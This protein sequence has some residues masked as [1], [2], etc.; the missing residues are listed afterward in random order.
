M[1]PYAGSTLDDFDTLMTIVESIQPRV[2]LELGTAQGNT[3]ANIC[4]LIPSAQI[5]TV[6][7]RADNQSGTLTT[8]E[9]NRE[10][11]GR[12][13]LELGYGDRVTQILENTLQLDLSRYLPGPMIDLAI[14]DACHDT[15]YVVNDYL[16][17]V[18]FVRAGGVVM[19]HDVHPSMTKHYHSGYRAC[20]MLR[21]RGYDIRYL[22]GTS[23]A[24]W[25]NG[26]PVFDT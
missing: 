24:V 17:A 23:W 25:I 6:N 5:F 4:H 16:K 18:P 20:I 2:V 14:V 10:Q 8:F 22:R 9:L 12:V 26:W 13:Y 15:D 11:I 7:A 1:P 3:V 21:K 19:L